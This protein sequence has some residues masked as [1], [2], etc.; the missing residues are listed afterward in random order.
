MAWEY[1]LV[2]LLLVLTFFVILLVPT[3]MN[4]NR[5]LKKLNKTAD[6]LNEDLPD[7]L[8]DISEITYRTSKASE[9]IKNTIEDLS[10]IEKTITR[11]IKE[12]IIE[13]AASIGGFLKAVQSFVTYFVK[14]K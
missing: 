2:A 7:I 13:T 1:A 9:H 11:E 3:V 6:T 10:E 4:L 12:P 5:V 8:Y 14:K